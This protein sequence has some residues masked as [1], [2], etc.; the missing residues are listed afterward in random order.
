MMNAHDLM[1]VAVHTVRL[2][3]SLGR[4][5]Q[6]MWDHD[7]GCL[8]VVDADDHVVAM[9][10]DRDICMAAYTRGLPIASMSVAS[11]ASH[12][13]HGVKAGDTLVRVERVMLSEQVRRVPVTDDDGKL[14]GLVSLNDI[15]RHVG[16]LSGGGSNGWSTES[17]ACGVATTLA[18]ISEHTPN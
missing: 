6:L 18:A 9:L 15:A 12:K 13:V 3:D 7:C 17:E 11:A 10:T 8:P 2:E 4:A 14:V 5:A 16:G 1:T